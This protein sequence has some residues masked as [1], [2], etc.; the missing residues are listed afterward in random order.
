[1][2]EIDWFVGILF[3]LD[4]KLTVFFSFNCDGAEFLWFHGFISSDINF[5]RAISCLKRRKPSK[6]SF[7]VILSKPTSI[8]SFHS[9]ISAIHQFL[10]RPWKSNSNKFFDISSQDLD[11]R[12]FCIKVEIQ[13]ILTSKIS[14]EIDEL[15][16]S[17]WNLF[18]FERCGR[19]RKVFHGDLVKFGALFD[20]FCCDCCLEFSIENFHA[21]F[22]K[23]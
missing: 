14:K 1:M 17:F 9:T 6:G 21:S 13:T 19:Y 20:F 23:L 7:L 18:K 22:P 12:R 2:E 11:G 5:L 15:W 8:E 10:D 16:M 3:L 4:E